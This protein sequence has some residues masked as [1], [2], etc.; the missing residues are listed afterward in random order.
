MMQSLFINYALE[1][2]SCELDDNLS[3]RSDRD[4]DVSIDADLEDDPYGLLDPIPIETSNIPMFTANTV[5]ESSCLSN[6]M[7]IS[8]SLLQMILFK[9]PKKTT[10]TEEQVEPAPI[11]QTKGKEDLLHRICLLFDAATSPKRVSQLTKAVSVI[12]RDDPNA[13]VRP[14]V[15]YRTKKEVYDPVS[16]R[17][18]PKRI[19]M[20]Y[21]YPFHLALSNPHTPDEVLQ[22]L[23]EAVK[24]YM[25]SDLITLR[26]G[27]NMDTAVM[28]LYG[29]CC[30]GITQMSS[31]TRVTP[32]QASSPLPKGGLYQGQDR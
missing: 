2:D 24:A 5:V 10:S 19:K 6:V 31:E 13:I 1:G 21:R 12:L 15:V 25:I 7:D 17:L 3:F 30:H 18:R 29:H 22:L 4:E 27:S 8:F 11:A 28:V 23:L 26:D 16:G 32:G 9:E 20:T 14:C